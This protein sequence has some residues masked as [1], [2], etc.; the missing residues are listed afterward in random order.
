MLSYDFPFMATLLLF[1]PLAMTAAVLLPLALGTPASDLQMKID[2]VKFDN[3]A[4]V[5]FLGVGSTQINVSQN[6]LRKLIAG[7]TDDNHY[8]V[9]ADV[10]ATTVYPS[11][12]NYD[13]YVRATSAAADS[14]LTRFTIQ[15][16]PYD[17]FPD[18]NRPLRI[19]LLDGV[20]DRLVELS[21]P[22]HSL[23]AGNSLWA[24]T[25]AIAKVRLSGD[26][27]S[28]D[29]W[30]KC[31]VPLTMTGATV[32]PVQSSHWVSQPVLVSPLPIALGSDDNNNH[33]TL[34]WKVQ[35]RAWGVLRD[36]L[37]PFSASASK[38]SSASSGSPESGTDQGSDTTEDLE[39][40]VD[41]SAAQGGFPHNLKVYRTVYFYPSLPA[42]MAVACLGALAGGLVMF[43]GIRK[44]SG[45]GKF[46][47]YLWP[48]VVLAL[49][50]EVIAIVLF[51]FDNSK[52]Q[53]GVVNLNPTLLIPAACLGA[54]SV[55]Y[56]FQIVE[57]W[58]GKAG[59]TS[60]GAT[61]ARGKS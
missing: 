12:E 6:A 40:S 22:L 36:S 3:G 31:L 15:A 9:F 23:K 17:T 14:P 43:F 45:P 50:I 52:I 25:H 55:L 30:N 47:K 27:I 58:L 53:I 7:Q 60:P 57:K 18:Q 28:V 48:N 8:T 33:T 29:L 54:V 4:V 21:I 24:Q 59:P 42:L 37:M 51:S 16:T 41:Y 5:K 32:S 49:I 61:P 38:Q 34:V 44:D 56:G 2:D 35:P 39:F 11:F 10:D 26:M 20:Q 1:R 19:H 13:F 46:F